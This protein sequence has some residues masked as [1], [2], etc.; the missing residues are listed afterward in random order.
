M[1]TPRK[2]FT[3]AITTV[4]L[5]GLNACSKDKSN[6][7]TEHVV[8]ECSEDPSKINIRIRN[9]SDYDFCNVVLSPDGDLTNYGSINEGESTCYRS[10]DFAYSIAYVKFFIGDK[11]FVFQP[12]CYFGEEPLP[13]GNHTY[14]IDITDFEN[15]KA[16]LKVG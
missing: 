16:S 4:F 10:F 6:N 8:A 2:L 7:C 15:G 14:S 12:F 5:L 9:V 13:A 1:K 11:E 3:L